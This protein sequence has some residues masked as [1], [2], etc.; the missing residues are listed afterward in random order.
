MKKTMTL[1][2]ATMILATFALAGCGQKD[3]ATPA[4]NKAAGEAKTPQSETAQKPGEE[5]F[6][7][8]IRH[9]NVRDTAKL[10]LK[11]L[12]DV[13]K[14]TEQ[15]VAGLKFELDGV[16]DTVNRD[17]KLKAEMSAGTQPPIFNLFGGADTKN[18]AAAGRLLPL[19][20]ILKE[21][22]IADSFF[23]LRE[24]TVDGK[25][26]GLPESGFIEGFFYNK[27]VF[28]EAGVQVPKTWDEL[29]KALETFKAKGII[30]IALGAGGGDGWSVNMLV[31]SLIVGFGGPEI[32]EGFATGKTKW[33]DPAVIEAFKRLQELQTKGYIDPNAL[34]LKYS[35][36]QANFYTGKAALLFDGSWAINA[37]VGDTSTVKDHAGFFRFP[38][39][40]G[41]GDGY[42]N[43]GWSNG[44]GFSAAVKDKE[45]ETVKAFIKNFYT[46]ENQKRGLVETSRIPSMKNITNIEGANALV[47]SVGEAQGA[48]KGAFPAYDSLV[49]PKIKVTLESTMQELIGGEITPEK[50]AERMQQVQEAANSG[51]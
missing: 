2:L 40:G 6:S 20:D 24:F 3:A 21:V 4:D 37:L 14:K 38:D 1:L 12:E 35:Q 18:Y 36:G 34:G 15:D 46:I 43:G 51:K 11:I 39:V 42:I 25:V 47:K 44:Y 16:E 30:P 27:K 45:L 17:V 8:T 9:I 33:T 28:D 10:T 48:A 22:G 7:M 41:P 23:D 26:Y 13:V 19:N 29:L 49:Q 31:N 32:Q 5:A 50:A